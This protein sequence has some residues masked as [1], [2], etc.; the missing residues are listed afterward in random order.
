MRVGRAALVVGALIVIAAAPPATAADFR[1]T[2]EPATVLYDAPSARAQPLYIYGRD[3]PLEVIVALEAWIKVRDAGGSIGWVEKKSLGD[4]RVVV[5]RQ[6]IA[7]VRASPDDAAP[8]VFRAELNVLLEPVEPAGAQT[9][10]TP[11]WLKVRHRDGQ[12]GYVRLA[13]VFG[14]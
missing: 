7:E 14:I 4:R 13:Q 5:V 10:A 3:T 9:T 12:V 11:G 2:G 6:P 8:I 1:V